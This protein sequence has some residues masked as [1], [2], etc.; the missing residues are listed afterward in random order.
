MYRLTQDFNH[1]GPIL[2]NS[3]AKMGGHYIFLLGHYIMISQKSS[4]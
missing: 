1:M 3:K 4:E 2:C